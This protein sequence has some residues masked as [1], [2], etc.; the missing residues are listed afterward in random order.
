[1]FVVILLLISCGC[2]NK[3]PETWWLKTIQIHYLPML[4]A[5]SL[6]TVTQGENQGIG[7]SKFLLETT[8]KSVSLPFPASRG[9]LNFY[10]LGS[11]FPIGYWL[12]PPSPPC[13]NSDCIGPTWI[14][15]ATP[16]SQGQA[17]QQPNSISNPN[18]PFH[19]AIYYQVLRHYFACDFACDYNYS[20]I[21]QK[22]LQQPLLAETRK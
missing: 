12:L 16:P 6:K 18:S 4:E 15:Q 9:C 19:L 14:T 21:H 20:K 1:M 5:R 22:V 17:D 3:L 13:K 10:F 7:R 8:G 11:F 2:C